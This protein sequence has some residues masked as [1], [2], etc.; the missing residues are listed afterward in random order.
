[1]TSSLAIK[2][3]LRCF[4]IELYAKTYIKILELVAVEVSADVDA[5]AAYDDNF[6]T[7]QNG[8]CHDGGQAAQQVASAVNDN[9]LQKNAEINIEY[10]ST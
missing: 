9:G 3:F 7:V 4:E 2:C 8:L 1:M 5:L 10:E 6:L